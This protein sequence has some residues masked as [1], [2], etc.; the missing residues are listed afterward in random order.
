MSLSST[1]CSGSYQSLDTDQKGA[2]KAGTNQ[3]RRTGQAKQ[4]Y[5]PYPFDKLSNDFKLFQM[6][7]DV[8]SQKGGFEETGRR[9]Q[10]TNS[11]QLN[12]SK[13]RTKCHLL[14]AIH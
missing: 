5:G 8:N 11:S 1:A 9:A 12:F 13:M 7:N 2:K 10:E 3:A 4:E 14:D 6:D